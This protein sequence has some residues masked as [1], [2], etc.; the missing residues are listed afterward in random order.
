MC[1][2][3]SRGALQDDLEVGEVDTL[4]TVNLPRSWIGSKNAKYT[5]GRSQIPTPRVQKQ[6]KILLRDVA[7]IN[8][9]RS[10]R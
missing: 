5:K 8:K 2:K 3:T 1:D 10:A 9:G 4:W 6:E 7:Q